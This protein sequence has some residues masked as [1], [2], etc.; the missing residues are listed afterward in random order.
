MNRMAVM[1]LLS[2]MNW[3]YVSYAVSI[4]VV[5][6]ALAN[7]LFKEG[8]ELVLWPGLFM[9]LMLTGL[10]LFLNQ[11]EELYGFPSGTYLLLNAAFYALIIFIIL[12]VIT[13][14]RNPQRP[15]VP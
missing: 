13:R 6:T 11:S 15:P 3:K 4:S 5:I 12:S 7:M 14:V 1:A 2:R 10:I 8:G 9:E